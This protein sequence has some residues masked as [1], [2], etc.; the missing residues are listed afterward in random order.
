[1]IKNVIKMLFIIL[2]TTFFRTVW[3]FF[4]FSKYVDI[5]IIIIIVDKV[6]FVVPRETTKWFLF[7]IGKQ[8]QQQR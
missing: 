4:L 1:M 6:A 8:R 7:L 5:I 2:K 3:I